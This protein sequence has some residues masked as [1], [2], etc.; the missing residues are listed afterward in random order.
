M[1]DLSIRNIRIGSEDV[2]VSEKA[3]NLGI[4][5]DCKLSMEHQVSHQCKQMYCDLRRIGQISHLLDKSSLQVLIS[6]FLLSRLDYC[7]SLLANLS[8]ESINRLQRFQNRAARLIFKKSQREPITPLLKQLHWLPV[9][10]RIDYKLAL[11]CHKCINNRAPMYLKDLLEIYVPSRHL[12]S[13][14]ENFLRVPAVKSNKLGGRAFS[15]VAPKI[16][17]SLP[18]EIRFLSSEKQFKKNLKTYLF[19]NAFC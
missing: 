12:R 15:Y 1:S 11:F 7:N 5:F 6:A 10:A 14:E 17:N 3:K 4:Y 19:T 9:T 2:A 8:S 18:R 13:A 16:W